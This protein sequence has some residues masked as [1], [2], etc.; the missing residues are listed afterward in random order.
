[1]SLQ[2]NILSTLT[3]FITIFEQDQRSEQTDKKMKE[4]IDIYYVE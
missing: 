2:V 4:L 3:E 1:M